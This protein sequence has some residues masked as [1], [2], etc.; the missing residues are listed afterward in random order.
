LLVSFR[1]EGSGKTYITFS[2]RLDPNE[3][4][5]EGVSGVSGGT[6]TES[7]A[8][9]VA[10]IAPGILFSRLYSISSYISISL[11]QIISVRNV[12]VSVMK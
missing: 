1:R 3:S 12:Q 9:D 8:N 6:D 11:V 2:A 4:V 7:S 10:P 5:L